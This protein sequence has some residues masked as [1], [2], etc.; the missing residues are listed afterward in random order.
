MEFRDR[1]LQL[2]LIEGVGAITIKKLL[3]AL[4]VDELCN[5]D[6]LTTHQ[7]AQKVEWPLEK[8]KALLTALYST[9]SYDK[10][11]D[12]AH[13]C[14]VRI[15]TLADVEYPAA[16]KQ[17]HAPPPI[18]Y[19]RGVWNSSLE[20]SIALVGSR[21]VDAYGKA[22]I[23]RFVPAL[24]QEGFGIVSGGA[25]G[26]DTV[27]HEQT[28]Q[29]SGSTLA[30]IGA[31]LLKPYPSSNQKLFEQIVAQGGAIMSPFALQVT[32]QPHN[33]PARNRIIAG[34]SYGTI[35]VQAAQ[36]SGAL[37][38]ASYARE[39]GRE[40]GAVPGTITNPL[41][42]GCHSLLKEGAT[43]IADEAELLLFAGV[44]GVSSGTQMVTLTKMSE[45][46][47][48]KRPQDQLVVLCA[49]PQEFD[50]L[51]LTSGL[52]FMQLQQKLSQ[53]QLEGV[54][55]QDISGRWHVAG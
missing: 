36:K 7:L 13:K 52:D 3:H 5:L 51:L 50:E 31:G 6:Q 17:I 16:L 9:E 26:A 11:I 35:V 48:I 47:Q 20:K 15:V 37:I 4:T 24:V 18:L 19:L 41:S 27:A 14:G 46:T 10:E 2:S 53:L 55:T 38:T 42:A 43:L 34:I 29:N 32:A 12:L 44:Q 25:I 30:V 39:E 40:V 54:V 28:L 23:E 21:Q 22:V 49:E 45:A 33:F 8:S 1:L